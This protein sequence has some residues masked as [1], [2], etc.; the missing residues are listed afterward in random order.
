MAGHIAG[1]FAGKGADDELSVRSELCAAVLHAT[2]LDETEI[3]ATELDETEIDASELDAPELDESERDEAEQDAPER[4]ATA[5]DAPE[6]GVTAAHD[7]WCKSAGLMVVSR[8][9][10]WKLWLPSEMGA[11][12]VYVEWAPV[13]SNWLKLS[14]QVT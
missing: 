3:D 12:E 7:C 1:Y 13:W 5:R 6:S 14:F 4:D 10:S 2:E 9:K 8:L 11:S